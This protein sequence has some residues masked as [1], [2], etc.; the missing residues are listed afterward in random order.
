[1]SQR[2]SSSSLTRRSCLRWGGLALAGAL[3]SLSGC[4]T[5]IEQ[6]NDTPATPSSPT[7]SDT[8]TA[9]ATPTS[10]PTSTRSPT[11]TPT[12]TATHSTS[13]QTVK[14]IE[15][16]LSQLLTYTNGKY[17]YRVKYPRGWT[18]YD[19]D[20]QNVEIRSTRGF[21]QLLPSIFK[22]EQKYTLEET[23]NTVIRNSRTN[24]ATFTVLNQQDVTLVSGQ[25]AHM[26]DWRYGNTD[27]RG[28]LFRAKYLV[29]VVGM[30]IYQVE[31]AVLQRNYTATVDQAATRILESFTLS[32]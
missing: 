15:F 16:D 23:V 8:P 3:S 24:I 4:L 13:T 19:S 12:A 17:G 30:T 9:T 27:N 28:G 21:G 5:L 26:I 11:L 6:T 20:P 10:T 22:T 18:I 7:P 1:M 29:T 14:K 25:P 31:F 2:E 32:G